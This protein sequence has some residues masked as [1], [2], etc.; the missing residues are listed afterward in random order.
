[1]FCSCLNEFV[2]NFYETNKYLSKSH[3]FYFVVVLLGANLVNSST[4]EDPENGKVLDIS[5]KDRYDFAHN[6]LRVGMVVHRHIQN[7]DWIPFNRQP[8]LHKFSFMAHRIRIIS[9]SSFEM[10]PNACTCYNA[11]LTENVEVRTVDCPSS[12]IH[13][14]LWGKQ[15]KWIYCAFYLLAQLYNQL[16]FGIILQKATRSNCGNISVI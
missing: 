2:L 3:C 5:F 7:G 9:G 11:D 14:L 6:D 10:H 16:V 1:M 13:V 12:Y 4:E 15:C 8:S